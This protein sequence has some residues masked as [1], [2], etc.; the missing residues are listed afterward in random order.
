MFSILFFR[1]PK[2]SRTYV[3]GGLLF[4]ER[5]SLFPIYLR[6]KCKWQ[7]YCWSVQSI[8]ACATLRLVVCLSVRQCKWELHINIIRAAQSITVFVWERERR[9]VLLSLDMHELTLHEYITVIHCSHTATT[10]RIDT[11]LVVHARRRENREENSI[12]LCAHVRTDR[13]MLANLYLHNSNCANI[14]GGK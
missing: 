13:T 4:R 12:M 8:G 2:Y 7:V 10:L 11:M 6:V 1:M 14:I 3:K 9:R 5:H